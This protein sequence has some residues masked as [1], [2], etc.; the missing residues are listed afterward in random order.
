MGTTTNVVGLSPTTSSKKTSSATA[1]SSGMSESVD[2]FGSLL[3]D[4]KTKLKTTSQQTA[5]QK[6]K[7]TQGPIPKHQLPRPSVVSSKEPDYLW[8]GVGAAAHVQ[9]WIN[10]TNLPNKPSVSK[11]MQ[12][13]AGLKVVPNMSTTSTT[14]QKQEQRM[15]GVSQSTTMDEMP[16]NPW[17]KSISTLSVPPPPSESKPLDSMQH[18][19]QTHVRDQPYT[20]R[21]C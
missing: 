8:S 5:E 21:V 6:Q 10:E 20:V 13:P 9:G 1:Q 3:T 2:P 16:Y 17:G 14:R 18:N 19:L 12:H 4:F 11:T 7:A 15:K